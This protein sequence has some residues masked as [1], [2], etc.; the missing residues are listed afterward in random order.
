MMKKA[1]VAITG[2][3]DEIKRVI[4]VLRCEEIADN[5]FKLEHGK[6]EAT[7]I[8]KAKKPKTQKTTKKPW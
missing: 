2:L 8:L 6:T 7:T 1:S 4:I 5:L 3:C